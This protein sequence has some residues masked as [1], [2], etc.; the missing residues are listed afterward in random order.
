MQIHE[1]TDN[2]K[3]QLD[4][5]LPNWMDP[6]AIAQKAGQVGQGI[7][8]IGQNIKSTVAPA[9]Q[10]LKTRRQ[11]NALSTASSK[12]SA[13]WT[14]YAKQLKAATSDPARYKQ[15]YKQSLMAFVQKNLLANRPIETA[16]NKQEL[17]QLIDAIT[18][19]EDNPQ[20]VA[21][22]MSKLVQQSSL[23]QQDVTRS[24]TP[25]VRV[26]SADP[27]VLQFRNKI[28]IINDK[29]D[30]AEKDTNKIPDQSFQAFL[31]QELAKVAQSGVAVQSTGKTAP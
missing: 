24:V 14:N 2:S 7:K 21:Q 9:Q 31:D 12:A 6:A 26:V 28:Y 27:A 8:T 15:L 3:P 23:S 4:E 11:T 1:I 20:Q 5:A 16:V 10:A 25:L 30:W 18:V 13:A 29:G 17:M 22:L 19:A